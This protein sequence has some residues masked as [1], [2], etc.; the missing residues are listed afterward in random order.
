MDDS[1]EQFRHAVKNEGLVAGLRVLNSRTP[2]RFTGV[3][4]YDHDMLRNVALVDSHDLAVH[5]GPDV[6]LVDAYCDYMS[7]DV[8]SLEFSDAL[9]DGRFEPKPG[10]PVISYCGVL[11]RDRQGVP[12]GSLCHFDPQPCQPRVS[13]VP[14]L[15]EVAPLIYESMSA[16]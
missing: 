13:D 10:N 6:R 3:F 4:R 7:D 14:L 12:Y 1:A 11:I 16:K 15:R 2:H 5:S 8:D 9:S